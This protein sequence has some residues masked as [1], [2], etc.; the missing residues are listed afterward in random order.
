MPSYELHAYAQAIDKDPRTFQVL[1]GLADHL[2]IM[3]WSACIPRRFRGV[4]LSVWMQPKRCW[5]IVRAWWQHY[6][7]RWRLCKSTL[8]CLVNSHQLM[9]MQVGATFWKFKSSVYTFLIRTSINYI[10]FW[11]YWCLWWSPASHSMSILDSETPKPDFCVRL[12]GAVVTYSWA[13]AFSATP[14]LQCSGKRRALGVTL[15]GLILA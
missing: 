5:K 2:L 13:R 14:P 10:S 1:L 3:S 6:L 8:A 4:L 12:F 11:Y 9:F 15:V 7:L